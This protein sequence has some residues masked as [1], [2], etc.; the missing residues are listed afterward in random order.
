MGGQLSIH[1]IHAL[2]R[3]S[4]S[5]FINWMV[6]GS[7]HDPSMG[8][9]EHHPNWR[10]FG[11]MESYL[12]VQ[13]VCH[14]AD[15]LNS[16]CESIL[17]DIL[18]A[19]PTEWGSVKAYLKRPDVT[20]AVERLRA[21]RQSGVREALRDGIGSFWSPESD[22]I[23]VLR[24]KLVHQRGHDPQREVENEIKQKNGQW[25]IVYPVDLP[26]N[27]IPIAYNGDTLVVDA[28]TGHWACR[29]VQNH[30][31]L[32][33]QNL[34]ARFALI[35]ERYR[36]KSLKFS[37]VSR[38]QGFPL[39]PGTPLPSLRPAPN[40]ES[41]PLTPSISPD[42]TMI[43]SEKEIACAQA[44]MRMREQ[45]DALVRKYCENAGITIVGIS[46][47]MPGSVLSHTIRG[48]DL[49]LI[50]ELRPT[51][52]SHD[53]KEDI[54]IRIREIDFEPL[55]TIFGI[56]SQMRDFKTSSLTD[57]AIEY[58]KACIDNALQ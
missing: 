24:N 47:G 2:E 21:H 30:I 1:A 9:T 41:T 10:F 31:H 52:N 54:E 27:V 13:Q 39:P 44:R 4:E 18:H 8:G 20:S 6:R 45:F 38:H 49:S 11:A 35:R 53:K 19:N 56:S 40:A 37:G 42:Y 14:A 28:K 33:D 16:Y 34:C 23:C 22:V 48:H 29:H 12:S 5:W 46:G 58:L 32:M 55:I 43:T 15:T 25:C 50:Y 36:P 57:E 26:E 17:G 51:D 3:L 7:I